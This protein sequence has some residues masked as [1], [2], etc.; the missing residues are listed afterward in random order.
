MGFAIS[1]LAVSGKSP[2]I[3]LGEL[4]VSKTGATEEFPESPIT[5]ANLSSGWFLVFANNFDSP[6]VSE[7]T[8]S[9]LSTGCEVLSCQVEEHVM[10]SSAT[11]HANAQR[12]WH[13]EHDAQESIYHLQSEGSMPAQFD[14]I[15]AT[16]KQQQDADGGAES[17]VDYIHDAPVALASSIVA[18]RH[19]QDIKSAS[20]D[21]FEV[22]TSGTSAKPWWRLW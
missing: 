17:D 5:C 22:L 3:V 4:G 18:F 16:L 12:I 15:F 1:W 8:L 10:F 21:P 6:L 11:Y 13:V 9:T 19:D 2:E 7:R 14:A 20:P